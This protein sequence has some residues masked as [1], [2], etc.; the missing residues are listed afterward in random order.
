MTR[1]RSDLTRNATLLA[2][3]SVATTVVVVWLS[4]VTAFVLPAHDPERLP[5]WRAIAAT[6]GAFCALSWGCLA[7]GGRRAILRWSL[8]AVSA[9]AV[10]LGLFGI[11]DMI[12]RAAERGDFEGYIVLMGLIL[13]GH[14]LAGVLYTLRAGRIER[15][16]TPLGSTDPAG[17]EL[18]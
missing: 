13:A 10:A 14:G 7:T 18:R 3:A 5:M 1:P 17:P 6:M 15:L 9:G 11:V 4:Y 16:G 12:R 8:L 2:L